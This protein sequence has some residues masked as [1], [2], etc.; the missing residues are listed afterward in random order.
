MVAQSVAS[1]RQTGCSVTDSTQPTRASPSANRYVHQA[2]KEHRQKRQKHDG[3]PGEDHRQDDG[4]EHD[5]S[6]N[7]RQLQVR[8]AA[9]LRPASMWF[10]LFRPCV[11]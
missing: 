7:A 8:A 6:V 1:H 9:L 2:E 11:C 10:N 3:P 4:N 5:Q